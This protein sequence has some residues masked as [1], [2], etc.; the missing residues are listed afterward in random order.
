LTLK[1]EAGAMRPVHFEELPV[2]FEDDKRISAIAAI[3]VPGKVNG[4]SLERIC[5][6]LIF[7]DDALKVRELLNEC[8]HSFLPK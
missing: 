6:S 3:P 7:G 2:L 8:G 5:W 1:A 4:G